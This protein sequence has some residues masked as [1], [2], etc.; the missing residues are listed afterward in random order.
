MP[1]L[2]KPKAERLSETITILKKLQEVGIPE[3]DPGYKEVKAAMTNWV[4]TGEPASLKVD[5]L[6][7][8]RRG[9]LTL[10]FRAGRAAELFLKS[11]P[12]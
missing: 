1:P 3:T 5:F 9:E 4:Q 12:V 8:G 10:P 7:H 6:R 11:V 2:Q